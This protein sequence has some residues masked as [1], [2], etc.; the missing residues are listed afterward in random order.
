LFYGSGNFTLTEY[1]GNNH[2]LVVTDIK[3]EL[4]KVGEI[5]ANEG[6]LLTGFNLKT[7]SWENGENYVL[8]T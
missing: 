4:L 8:L 2:K 6:D 5:T 7:I 1:T 3:P